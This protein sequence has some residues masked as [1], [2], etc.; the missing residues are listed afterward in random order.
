MKVNKSF[1]K[2]FRDSFVSCFIE[3]FSLFYQLYYFWGE[4]VTF[5]NYGFVALLHLFS[6]QT[7]MQTFELDNMGDS[8]TSTTGSETDKV[9]TDEKFPT[10]KAVTCLPNIYFKLEQFVDVKIEKY[11]EAAPE[12]GNNQVRLY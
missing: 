1:Q 11:S 12:Q 8:T 2:K 3:G 7:L 4:F 9:E 6:D 5:Y 10:D